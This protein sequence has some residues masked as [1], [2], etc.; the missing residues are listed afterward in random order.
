[1]NGRLMTWLLA[2][3]CAAQAG[4]AAA[5]GETPESAVA[6]GPGRKVQAYKLETVEIRGTTRMSTEQLADELGLTPGTPL[7]DDLVMTTRTRLLG[8]GLFKSAILVMRKGSKPGFAKLIVEVEDDGS[9]LGDWAMGGELDVTVRER[10]AGPTA[11]SANTPM[12]YRVSL[13]GRN[14]FSEL[15]RG[16]AWLDFDSEGNVRAGQIAYGLPRFTREAAQFDA[17]IAAVDPHYRYLDAMGFGGRA[18]G[19]WAR[20]QAGFGEVQYGAGMYVNKKPHFAVPGFPAAVAGPKVAYYKETRLHTFYPGEGHLIGASLLLSPVETENSII[21]LE[22]A[23]TFDFSKRAFLTFDAKALTV[24]TDGVSF[25]AESRLDVPFGGIDPDEDQAEA[26]LRLRGGH[27]SIG[28]VSLL[29]S[30]AM[31]GVR[32]HSSGFIAELALKITRS[33]EDLAPK[34]I[35]TSPPPEVDQP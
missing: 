33:P 19:L 23:K 7:D 11:S 30:A 32:Y 34:T 21:E 10:D 27:D 35:G 16:S 29:G 18:Q 31:L 20:S 5:Q 25:R 15:H 14:L 6:V 26:F 17:E 2:C 24:G 1:M 22:M 12:D 13:V 9:V 8:L 28:K 3:L 4:P